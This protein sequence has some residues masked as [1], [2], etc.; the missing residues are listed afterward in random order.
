MRTI[1]IKLY[2]FDE[3]SEQSKRVAICNYDVIRDIDYI[4]EESYESY[5]EFCKI[6]GITEYI[7]NDKFCLNLNSLDDNILELKG[8]RLAKWIWNNHKHNLFTG[9]WYGYL[10]NYTGKVNHN[11]IFTKILESG[12]YSNA[13]KSAITL[14]NECLLTGMFYDQI[15]LKNIYRFLDYDKE[16]FNADMN[17]IELFQNCLND[18]NKSVQNEI[19]YIYSDKHITEYYIMNNTEFYKN[20]EQYVQGR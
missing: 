19:A 10:S 18:F 6:F 8:I 14:T 9:K 2:S 3:L 20:G 4:Q 1:S 5:K 17:I 11:R 15:I 13:Y 7:C 16:Y 12:K